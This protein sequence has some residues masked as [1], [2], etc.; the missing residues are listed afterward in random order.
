MFIIFLLLY[1]F[2]HLG[3]WQHKAFP[4]SQVPI[5][6]SPP[7]ENNK[8]ACCIILGRVCWCCGKSLSQ[9]NSSSY[10]FSY[11]EG[12]G[13]Q[14]VTVHVYISPHMSLKN[15]P[16]C[17]AWLIIALYQQ[18]KLYEDK[19]HVPLIRSFSHTPH[20]ALSFYGSKSLHNTPFLH[21]CTASWLKLFYV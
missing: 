17:L 18:C 9:F 20:H 13:F 10:L 1:I 12:A 15:N 14:V 16:K 6:N 11:I 3:L 19:D 5:S 2:C 7:G 4:C 21:I 8:S